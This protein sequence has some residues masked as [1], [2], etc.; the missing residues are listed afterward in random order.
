MATLQLERQERGELRPEEVR[1]ATDDPVLTLPYD[2][3][4]LGRALLRQ[5]RLESACRM[6]T[7]ANRGFEAS[8]AAPFAG[9]SSA[10]GVCAA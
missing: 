7:G 4:R 6:S 5:S 2:R 3:R 9:C 1:I 8:A 10:R